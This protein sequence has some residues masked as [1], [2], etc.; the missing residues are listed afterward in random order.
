[1]ERLERFRDCNRDRISKALLA[2]PGVNM[3]WF[4]ELV[5]T[6]PTGCQVLR[7]HT[8]LVAFRYSVEQITTQKVDET[9]SVADSSDLPADD[10][11]SVQPQTTSLLV[12]HSAAKVPPS[13]S[14]ASS[15][16]WPLAASQDWPPQ[17]PFCGRPAEPRIL[18]L[19]F[20]LRLAHIYDSRY[21]CTRSG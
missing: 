11:S 5:R 1:M 2:A 10:A 7:L 14:T 21:S 9:H 13:S 3:Y 18:P 6:L 17:P 4:A 20:L 16:R 19:G 15:Q 12:D 8:A